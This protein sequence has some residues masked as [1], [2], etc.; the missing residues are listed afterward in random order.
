MSAYDA[1]REFKEE[2]RRIIYGTG[3]VLCRCGKRFVSVNDHTRHRAEMT[4]AWTNT[5][6]PMKPDHYDHLNDLTAI[7]LDHR[8]YRVEREDRRVRFN[9]ERER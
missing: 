2:A 1:T 7:D 3:P 6:K 4:L 8:V 9:E 5:V